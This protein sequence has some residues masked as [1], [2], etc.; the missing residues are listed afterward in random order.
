MKETEIKEGQGALIM[1]TKKP[2]KILI[3]EVTLVCYPCDRGRYTK[4]V[5]ISDKSIP[6][7]R[8]EEEENKELDFNN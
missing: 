6:I 1:R 4:L 2:L 5:F 3:G 8:I 7:K